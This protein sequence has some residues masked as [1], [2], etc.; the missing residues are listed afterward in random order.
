MRCHPKPCLQT[1]RFELCTPRSAGSDTACDVL[2]FTAGVVTWRVWVPVFTINFSICPLWLRV[3]FVAVV[4][5]GF[6]MYW[7]VVYVHFLLIL[8]CIIMILWCI[9]LASILVA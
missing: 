3:P 6:T 9:E 5:F 4:S 7:C 1:R 8:T 2:P